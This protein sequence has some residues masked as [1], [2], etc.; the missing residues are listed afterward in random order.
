LKRVVILGAGSS[1]ID[2]LKL[3][4]WEK[5]EKEEVWSLNSCFKAMPYLPKRELWVDRDFFKK[6]VGELQKLYYKGIPMCA[7]KYPNLGI[8]ENEIKQYNT[9]REKGN[10][11]GKNAIQ[12]NIIYYGRMGL[13]GIFALSVAIAEGYDEIILLGYDFGSPSLKHK[14]T[15]WYQEDI[16]KLNIASTGAGRPE[17]YILPDNNMR[18]ELEDF[19]IFLQESDINI[20]NVS[21]IS[22]IPYFNKIDYSQFF[23]KIKE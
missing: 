3:G 14:F 15:H 18:T 11:F 20:Y 7:K 9:S 4:L 8:L 6:E 2:G 22:N 12:K 1:V 13:C 10:Y 23:E 16:N 21:P 17:V 19:K 5:I